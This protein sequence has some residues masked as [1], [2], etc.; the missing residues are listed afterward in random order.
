MTK[1]DNFFER[2]FWF[3]FNNLRPVLATDLKFFTSVKRGLKL[4]DRKIL[5]LIP[6]FVKVTG[7]KL[8]EKPSC[9]PHSERVRRLDA[10]KNNFEKLS[11]KKVGELIPSWCPI[12]TILKFD[13][14]FCIQTRKLHENLL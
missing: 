14:I 3:K 8:I 5:V 11:I 7:E 4:K 1:T 2:W 6:T 13:D 12:S 9:S 10:Y